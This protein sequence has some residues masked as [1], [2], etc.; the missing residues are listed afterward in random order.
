MEIDEAAVERLV[1]HH[2][3]LGVSGLFLAGTCGEG[4]WMPVRERRRLVRAARAVVNGSLPLAVQVSDNSAA[5]ILE[6][7]DWALEDGADIVVIAPPQF[8]VNVSA[9]AIRDLFL[10]AVRQSPLPVCIY[11]RGTNGAYDLSSA[12]LETIYREENV[13]MVKDSSCDPERNAIALK[14]RKERE[15]L[16]VFNGDEFDCIK[17]LSDGYDGLLLGG[18]VFNGVLARQIMEAVAQGK[19]DKA[20]KLQERMNRLMLDVYGGKKIECWLSGLK[21]L[22]VEMGVF[23]TWRNY[24]DFPLTTECDEAIRRALETEAEVLLPEPAGG[25]R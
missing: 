25:V 1:Q 10:A 24:P 5:R 22:L 8:M 23:Q 15:N 21:K 9:R 20:R 14:V 19:L 18:A 17:Y 4:P 16:R 12:D 13:V 7:A 11:D 3:R 2:L 6:N